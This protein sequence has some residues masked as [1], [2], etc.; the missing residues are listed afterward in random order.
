MK[1]AELFNKY[2]MLHWIETY[3]KTMLDCIFE[4]KGQFYYAFSI[5][6]PREGRVI[7]PIKYRAFKDQAFIIHEDSC[8]FKRLG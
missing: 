7:I 1:V 4:K 2:K 8:S 5:P 6:C 3:P